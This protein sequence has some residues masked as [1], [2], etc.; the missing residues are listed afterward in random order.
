MLRSINLVMQ[1]VW[2]TSRKEHT[3][4]RFGARIARRHGHRLSEKL[5]VRNEAR[6]EEDAAY[7]WDGCRPSW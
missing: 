7:R 3:L 2:R 6:G 5:R 4:C 1:N